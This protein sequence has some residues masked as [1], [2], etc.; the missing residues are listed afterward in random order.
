MSFVSYVLKTSWR[1]KTADWNEYVKL[2]ADTR[3]MGCKLCQAT[4]NITY[5]FGYLADNAAFQKMLD[6]RTCIKTYC[7]DVSAGAGEG[8]CATIITQQQRTCRQMHLN[9]DMC[10]ISD[11]KYF[12][13][14]YAYNRLR[15]AYYKLVAE[16]KRF[17]RNKFRNVK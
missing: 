8:P 12:Y 4:N 10:K 7:I 1:T 6:A 13:R 2:R 11:C 5:N 9:A 16:R 3:E 17:W 15:H 14:N